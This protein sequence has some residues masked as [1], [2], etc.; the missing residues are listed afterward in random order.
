MPVNW[1]QYRLDVMTQ[2]KR[3]KTSLSNLEDGTTRVT[4][5]GIDVTNEWKETHQAIL[6]TYQDILRAISGRG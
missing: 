5:D 6:R 2:I 4:K 1:E 3:A